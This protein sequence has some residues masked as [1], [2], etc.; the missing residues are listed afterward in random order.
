[1]AFLYAKRGRGNFDPKETKPFRISRSKIDLFLEC[2]RCFYLDQHLGIKR[3]DTYPLTL[4]LAV[5]E[6]L[7]KEFDL[8]R[9]SQDPHPIMEQYHID[10]VPFKHKDLEIWRDAMRRGIEYLDPRTNLSI[11]GGIDD[12]WVRPN[13]ELLIVDYKAKATRDQ[14]TLD[15][16]LGK[17]YQR[18]AEVYQWLFRKNGFRVSTT[19]YFV[20]VNGKKDALKFDGKLEFDM[21]IIP[22]E[23]NTDW[24]EPTILKIKKCLGSQILPVPHPDCAYCAYR[25]F[26]AE[27]AIKNTKPQKLKKINKESHEKEKAGQSNIFGESF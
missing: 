10:A 14:I 23:G 3:P 2:P 12:V 18:Q 21:S 22:C 1:M 17:Q 8:L 20:F 25:K 16:D 5:D 7:K 15:G 24:I 4:N 19:A 6:L 27:A 26:A 13:G 9:E 11:R